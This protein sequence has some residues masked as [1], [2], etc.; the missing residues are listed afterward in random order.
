MTVLDFPSNPVVDQIFT[1]N[2]QAWYW[3]GVAWR[4]YNAQGLPGDTGPTGPIG[5]TGPQGE[6]GLDGPTGPLGP[7][8]PTGPVSTVP[9]PTGPLGPTGATGPTGPENMNVD[10]GA[11]N[12]VYGGAIT[13]NAGGVL[14]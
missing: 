4:I 2:G 7:T 14:G 1:H 12:S 13:I 10:G 9:G 8:G 6:I 11:P 5:P 3:D